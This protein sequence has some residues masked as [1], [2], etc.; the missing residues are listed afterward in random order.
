V[1]RLG[2]MT[3]TSIADAPA[4]SGAAT[5]RRSYRGDATFLWGL[6][7]VSLL[8]GTAVARLAARGLASM[9]AGLAPAEWLILAGLT[10]LFLYMEGYRGFQLRWVPRVVGR[11]EALRTEPR[12]WY[13]ALAPL[14]AMGFISSSRRTL[15]WSWFATALIVVAVLVVSRFPHPW[16][17]IVDTAVAAALLYGLLSLVVAALRR[18]RG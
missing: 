13:R 10:A 2:M 3:E 14:H 6:A 1:L 16:R 15:F 11:L 8:L 4:G 9:Q 7:G 17:G 18:L 5:L 12:G